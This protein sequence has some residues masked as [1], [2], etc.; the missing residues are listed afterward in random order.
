MLLANHVPAGSAGHASSRRST[1][2]RCHRPALARLPSRA[3]A[4]AKRDLDHNQYVCKSYGGASAS[5]GTSAGNSRQ[6]LEALRKELKALEEER[7]T[8]VAT[9]ESCA[10]T[11]VR[12]SDMSRLL[13]DLA[14]EKVKQG[15][16][17]GA[18]QVLQ[19]KKSLK[20]MIDNSNNKAQANFALAGKLATLIGDKH[21]QL[22]DLMG[23]GAAG[24]S[25]ASAT[26]S[27]DAGGSSWP[28]PAP[29]PAPLSAARPSSAAGTSSG[30]W[31]TGAGIGAVGYELPWQKSLLEAQQ[32]VRVAEAEA[33]RM[34]RLA[35][36]SA[37]DS[38]QAARDRLAQR[39]AEMGVGAGSNG[40]S[41]LQARDRLRRT[42]EDSIQEAR[43]RL[44]EQDA[45][46]LEYCRRIVA[47]YRRGEYVTEQELEFAFEQLERRLL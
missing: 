3:A 13:E 23:G 22:L 28:E 15:D 46:I 30:S 41:I 38:I 10:R 7:D 24:V 1:S 25:S 32:R 37:E 27:T 44:R 29:R 43:A 40:E 18:K 21:N 19:E 20:E 2:F 33:S 34:G 17:G 42:A 8:A 9:A 4:N 45:Q 47:R 14:L 6:Q 26:S 35:A 12:L 11:C 31:A 5:A 39:Q 36:M 16:E